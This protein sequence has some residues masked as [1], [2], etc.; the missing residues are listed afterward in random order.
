[1]TAEDPG[2][3]LDLGALMSQLNQMQHSLQEAQ[4]SAAAQVIEGTAGGG[5]VR[6]RV[7]GG[8]VFES[9]TISP[10]VLQASD[11]GMVEDLVLAA[12]RDAVDKVHDAQRQ[13]FGGIDP[14]GGM[15]GQGGLGGLGGL[16]GG[17]LDS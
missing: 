4:A 14:T 12:L 16:L 9:V 13:A 3:G 8:M 10:E 11:A 15:G 6:V 2:E 1:M 5:A 17:P 7:T